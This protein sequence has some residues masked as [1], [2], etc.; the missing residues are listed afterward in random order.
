MLNTST[1]G[2]AGRSAFKNLPAP[3]I[4]LPAEQSK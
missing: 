1:S 4:S 2:I 3:E